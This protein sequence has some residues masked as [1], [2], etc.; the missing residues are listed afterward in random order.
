LRVEEPGLNVERSDN[1]ERGKSPQSG[2][3]AKCEN[4]AGGGD[5][6]RNHLKKLSETT[7]RKRMGESVTQREGVKGA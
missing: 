6:E 4:K 5:P 2:G 1:K 7:R 3:Y